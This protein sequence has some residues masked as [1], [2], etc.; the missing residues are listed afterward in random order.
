[1]YVVCLYQQP[2]IEMVVK[3]EHLIQYYLINL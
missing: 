3:E 1:M 2:L